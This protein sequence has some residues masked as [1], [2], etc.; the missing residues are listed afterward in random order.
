MKSFGELEEE[1]SDRNEYNYREYKNRAGYSHIRL[2]NDVK[3]GGKSEI[4][5]FENVPPGT[6]RLSVNL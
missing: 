1:D 4:M 6:Y 2:L 3:S 5:N